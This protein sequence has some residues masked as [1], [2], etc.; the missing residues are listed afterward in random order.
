MHLSVRDHKKWYE[1]RGVPI[2]TVY[3]AKC[4]DCWRKLDVGDEVV[5][6]E[7]VVAKEGVQTGD[8]GVVTKVVTSADGS[9]ITVRMNS[10]KECSFIRSEIRKKSEPKQT[11]E[12]NEISSND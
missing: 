12:V 3:P 11:K 9:L 1:D 7:Q 8:C 2:G 6:R 5:V 4:P 10:G